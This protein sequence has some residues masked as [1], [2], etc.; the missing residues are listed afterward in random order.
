M[1]KVCKKK[2]SIVT[3]DISKNLKSH[4]ARNYYKTRSF[5]YFTHHILRQCFN[6]KCLALPDDGT[7]KSAETRTCNSNYV[8]YDTYC[9]TRSWFYVELIPTW[10]W[11][12]KSYY[13]ESA[14]GKTAHKKTYDRVHSFAK[15]TL[16]SSKSRVMALTVTRWRRCFR[17]DNTSKDWSTLHINF[18]K[19]CRDP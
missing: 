5:Y 6:N 1:S 4:A 10:R 2:R 17:G 19:L 3:S 14:L 7:I 18:N 11:F 8:N 13:K 16:Y 12:G 15:V 9:G